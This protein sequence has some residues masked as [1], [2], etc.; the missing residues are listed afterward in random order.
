VRFLVPLTL[1]PAWVR[2]ISYLLA[3]TWGM[4]AM[5]VAAAGG[6]PLRDIAI[7]LG[8]GIGYAVIGSLIRSSCWIRPA[9]TPRCR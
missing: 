9:A 8:L 7:C 4:S 2:P 1:L 3:P 6:F 5:R